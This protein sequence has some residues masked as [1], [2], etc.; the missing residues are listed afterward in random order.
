M[1]ELEY[2]HLRSKRIAL[3]QSKQERARKIILVTIN[4]RDWAV[5]INE[6]RI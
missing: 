1:N 2:P 6:H 3:E 5:Q 4:D